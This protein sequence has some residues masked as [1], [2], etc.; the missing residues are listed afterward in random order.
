M[1]MKL[2]SNIR[3]DELNQEF[4]A[5]MMSGLANTDIRLMQRLVA[6]MLELDMSYKTNRNFELRVIEGGK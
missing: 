1:Q 4:N 6:I 3:K 2:L 5:I